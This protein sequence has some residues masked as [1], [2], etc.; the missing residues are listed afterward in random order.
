[1]GENNHRQ[2]HVALPFPKISLYHAKNVAF[3]MSLYRLSKCRFTRTFEQLMSLSGVDHVGEVGGGLHDD[4]N[5][6]LIRKQRPCQQ[7]NSCCHVRCDPLPRRIPKPAIKIWKNPFCQPT[8]LRGPAECIHFTNG[9]RREPAP[10][11]PLSTR[12]VQPAFPPAK[13]TVGRFL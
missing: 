10:A 12:P 6:G 13:N 8:L 9:G 11:Q 3:P 7:N 4:Y 5:R 1:M 2:R